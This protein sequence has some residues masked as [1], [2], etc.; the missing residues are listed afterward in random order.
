[1]ERRGIAARQCHTPGPETFG[2]FHTAM[3]LFEEA[4]RLAPEGNEDAVLRYNT[5]ARILNRN[6]GIRPPEHG[7][8]H[9]TE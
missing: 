5:C 2:W 9:R 8:L 4:I 7:S 3:Q 6:P 1:M